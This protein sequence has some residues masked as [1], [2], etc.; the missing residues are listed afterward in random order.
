MV[1]W[2][3][4]LRRSTKEMQMMKVRRRIMNDISHEE[5]IYQ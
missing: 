3:R 2:P 1:L 4:R 5:S